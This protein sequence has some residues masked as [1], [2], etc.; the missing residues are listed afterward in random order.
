MRIQEVDEHLD[1][2]RFWQGREDTAGAGHA[3]W[4]TVEGLAD[5]YP[6]MACKPVA[7]A[8]VH[9]GHDTI[10]IL[11]GK[12][13]YTPKQF[14]TLHEIVEDAWHKWNEEGRP[15]HREL[16]HEVEREHG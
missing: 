4:Q 1:Y 15:T 3:F 14:E 2:P 7:Q 11:L 6:C 9:G 8:L 13:A 12:G 16:R 5:T 10:N